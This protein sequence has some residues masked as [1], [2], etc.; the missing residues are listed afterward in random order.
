MGALYFARIAAAYLA[1]G[2][3]GGAVENRSKSIILVSSVAGFTG[4]PGMPL[5]SAS[6]HALLG[7]MRSLR[8]SLPSS[9]GIRINAVCPG[10]TDTAMVSGLM[11]TSTSRRAEMNQAEDVARIIISLAGADEGHTGRAIHVAD[12]KGWDIEPIIH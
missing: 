10:M 9:H 6:K 4:A 8:S 12:G 5:Y 1:H 11:D 2:N 7:L 3:D